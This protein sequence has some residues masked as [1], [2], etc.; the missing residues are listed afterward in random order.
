MS[1]HRGKAVIVGCGIAGL[2]AALRLHRIGWRPIVVERAPQRRTGGY[3]VTFSGLGYDAAE[4]MGVLPAPTERHITPDRMVYVKPNGETR[5]SAPGATVRAMLGDR[6][7]NLLRGD[8][9]DVLHDA[10]AGEVEIRFGS[11]V[12]AIAQDDTG[13]DVALDDGTVERADLLIGAD[14]LHSTT[15]ALVFGPEEDFRLDLDH[16]VGVFMLDPLPPGVREGT[17][18]TR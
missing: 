12:A 2:A 10:I 6:A 14:G 1:T 13:V 15:R 16:V 4:R 9:E 7:L 3:A 5:F 17:T 11:T 18:S 8:V